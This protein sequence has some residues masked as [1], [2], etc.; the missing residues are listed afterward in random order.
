M[1]NSTLGWIFAFVALQAA[2]RPAL[3]RADEPIPFDRIESLFR[4]HC[5]SCHAIEEPKGEFRIDKL[6]SDF[7]KGSDGDAWL[8]VM[9]RLEFGDM[10]PAT[11]PALL[12]EERELMITSIARHQAELPQ[13]QAPTF[14]RLT[15]RE[16][17]RTMQDLLG[18][19]IEFGA[20]LP[21]DG[22]SKDGFRN[23]G[24]VLRMSPV[25]YETFLQIADE[26]LAE[27]IV[28]GPP[29]VVHRYRINIHEFRV[30]SLPKPTDRPGE[31]F[32]YEGHPFEIKNMGIAPLPPPG[33]GERP[34]VPS[35]RPRTALHSTCIK[36]FAV[37]KP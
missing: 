11:E 13:R 17:E 20:K 26:A 14:R 29:P 30:E 4:K 5:Y 12:K 3:L 6:D 7:A 31:S 28:S 24:N 27:A 21:E 8:A 10:P 9:D 33:G 16:Y 35:G 19:P 37:A 23:D 22:K 36:R 25:Q 15:R 32:D 34:K 2:F 18:L 1:H